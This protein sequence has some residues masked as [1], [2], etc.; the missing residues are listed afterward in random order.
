MIKKRALSIAFLFAALLFLSWRAL[1]QWLPRL[2]NIWL[3]TEMSLTVNGTPGWQGGGLHSAGFSLMAGECTL[4]DVRNMTL[5]WHSWRWHVDIDAVTLNSDCLQHVPASS[6]T[7]PSA[8]LA[9]WQ[10]RLPA[11]D[12]QVKT[13]TLQPWQDYAGQ[14]RLSSDGKRQQTLDYQGDQLAF[15]AELNEKRL[16]L[17]ESM[18]ATPAG[19]V[20]LQVSG[21]MEL[22]DTL[23]AAPVQGRLTGKLDSGQA[24][25]PLSLLLDWHH[26]AG[27][28]CLNA[29]NDETP[30]ISLPWQLTD[31]VI[32]VTNGVWRWPYADQPLSGQVAITLQH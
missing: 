31:E 13:F 4:V 22:A 17:H 21:E 19:F 18:L 29:A 27:E 24:P 6:S 7:E 3:P 14:V 25:D 12:I 32:Q 23:D 16:T 1:P 5:R 20:R 9:Q 28:L 10:Q 26:Q 15:K 2:A 8:Q 30:L 11:A